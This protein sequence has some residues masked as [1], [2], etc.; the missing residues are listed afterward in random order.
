MKTS[1]WAPVL[2]GITE[3]APAK[4]DVFA[5]FNIILVALAEKAQI[6]SRIHQTFPQVAPS[7]LY[8][9]SRRVA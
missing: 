3:A 2:F 5:V 4:T 1:E 7:P 8:G 6:F 9:M